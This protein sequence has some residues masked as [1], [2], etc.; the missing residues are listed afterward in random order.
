[1]KG[2]DTTRVSEAPEREAKTLRASLHLESR[3][4]RPVQNEQ[5]QLLFGIQ[6]L[7]GRDPTCEI[8]LADDRISRKHALLR[9]D[10]D[11]VRFSDLGSTNGSTRNG[12]P[13]TEEIILDSGDELCLGNA[14]TFEVRIVTRDEHINSLRLAG[15]AQV[16]L[17]APS[18]IIIGFADPEIEDVDF[19][20]YDPSIL[21]RH[22][23]IE[24]F[25][26]RTFLITALDPA[27]PISV[28]SK[29]TVETEIKNNYLIELGKT[30]LRFERAG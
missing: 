11:A 18:D 20:I 15:D 13:V 12:E 21:P 7:I 22:A 30:L 23:R 8:H 17:L 16:F 19:K 28:N 3:M 10:P 2:N 5:I 27:R 4:G 26:G 25:M 24:L 1:M 14:W 6:M 29:P 9:I